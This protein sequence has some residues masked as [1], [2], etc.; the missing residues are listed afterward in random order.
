LKRSS[1]FL[2]KMRLF[3]ATFTLFC[4]VQNAIIFDNFFI[5]P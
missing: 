4:E 1:T 5:N 2:H 3:N